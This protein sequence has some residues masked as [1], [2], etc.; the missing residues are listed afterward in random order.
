MTGSFNTASLWR[1]I[2]LRACLALDGKSVHTTSEQVLVMRRSRDRKLQQLVGLCVLVGDM[3]A[4]RLWTMGMLLLSG[5]A[6]PAIALVD[7]PHGIVGVGHGAAFGPSCMIRNLDVFA[8]TS[9]GGTWNLV[10][11]VVAE[12]APIDGCIPIVPQT[13]S[14]SWSPLA[15]GC[16]PASDGTRMSLC[17]E[18]LGSGPT[19]DTVWRVCSVPCS[20]DTSTYSGTASFAFV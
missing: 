14:G 11:T 12:G 4:Q 15:G 13:F 8:G 20:A 9:A 17:I 5:L 2:P 7:A 16:L 10:L 18:P 19:A 6:T 1:T 3:T